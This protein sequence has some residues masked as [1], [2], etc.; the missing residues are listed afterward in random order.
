MTWDLQPLHVDQYLRA[1][2]Y[3]VLALVTWEARYYAIEIDNNQPRA[4]R[5]VAGLAD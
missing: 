3:Q 5:V 1:Q 2:G 4:A